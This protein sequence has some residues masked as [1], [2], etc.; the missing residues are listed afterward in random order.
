MTPTRR[1]MLKGILCAAVAPAVALADESASSMAGVAVALL[2]YDSRVPRSIALCDLYSV[3]MIDVAKEPANFWRS[4][5][6]GFP[7]GRVV[8]LTRWSDFVQV[9]TLLQDKGLRLR[10]QARRGD[11][12]YWEMI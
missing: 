1:S 5:R 6:T 10:A 4:L 3:R 9:R 8:G 11:I 2:V 12:F 7:N